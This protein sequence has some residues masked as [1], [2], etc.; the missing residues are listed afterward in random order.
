V[1][2]PNESYFNQRSHIRYI[3]TGIAT[4]ETDWERVIGRVV[5]VGLGGLLVY[6]DL[7]AP[8]GSDTRLCFSVSGLKQ[9]P[10]VIAKGKIVWSQPGKVGLEFIDEPTGLSTLLLHLEKRNATAE[11]R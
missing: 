2:T 7:N 5:S 11:I 1:E 4:I 6:C 10:S 8:T 3:V 9:R